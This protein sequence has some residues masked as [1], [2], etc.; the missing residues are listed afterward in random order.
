MQF[1]Y[2]DG[3]RSKYYNATNVGDCAT[4]AIA[5]A[6]GLD[7]KLVYKA[8]SKFAG[9]PVRNGCP[10]HAHKKLLALLGW[11]W[12]ATMAIGSGCKVHLRE[13]ELPSTCVMVVSVSRHLTCVKYGVIY[14]TY[15]CS[16]VGDRCVYGYWIMPWNWTTAKGEKIINDFLSPKKPVKP[17][18]AKTPTKKT[19]KQKKS[20]KKSKKRVSDSVRIKRLEKRVAELEALI[21][22]LKK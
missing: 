20:V 18:K 6:T 9:K 8:L 3:G 19:T 1:I 13:G 2:N 4:R 7:Y 12:T 16:R 5:N 15:D 11:E 10:N 17:T 14:D 22:E 21:A